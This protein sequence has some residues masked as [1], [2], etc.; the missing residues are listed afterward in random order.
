MRPQAADRRVPPTSH[1]RT[2]SDDLERKKL[3][4]LKR[5]QMDVVVEY[6]GIGGSGGARP[7]HQ[8]AVAIV[9]WWSTQTGVHG[10]DLIVVSSPTSY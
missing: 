2:F 8:L 3:A 6:Y 5:V 10:G 4:A 9:V 7:Q 1:G